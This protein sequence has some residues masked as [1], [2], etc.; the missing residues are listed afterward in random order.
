MVVD[1]VVKM[2]C[3]T[4]S[5][6]GR[7][8]A[9]IQLGNGTSCKTELYFECVYQE[10]CWS[11]T[12]PSYTGQCNHA[13]ANAHRAVACPYFFSS[14]CCSFLAC[15]R[16]E[17]GCDYMVFYTDDSMA[18]VH[19][20]SKYTGGKDGHTANWPGTAGLSPLEIPASHFFFRWRTD[21]SVSIPLRFVFRIFSTSEYNGVE[22]WCSCI[23]LY[24]PDT[25]V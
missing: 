10:R 1:G 14:C 25:D 23:V 18:R 11:F 21:G 9:T 22:G 5:K 6:H 16:T 4:G 17:H 24:V 15:S 19:G 13:R 20:E 7:G 3:S 12:M 8:E 2:F